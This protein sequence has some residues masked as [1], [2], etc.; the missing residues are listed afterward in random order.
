MSIRKVTKVSALIIRN[1]SYPGFK[2]LHTLFY[3]KKGG[4]N[5]IKFV[6]DDLINYLTPRAL[7]YWFMDDGAYAVSGFYL[8]TKGFT[9]LDVY[10]LA[11]MLHYK[12]NLSITVQWDEN[13]PVIYIY[14]KS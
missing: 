9:F 7:A 8:H 12:L 4:N 2:L 5:Y 10:R 14:I 13:R 6:S 3:I 11:G 1:R